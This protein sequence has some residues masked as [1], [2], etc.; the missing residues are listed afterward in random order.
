MGLEALGDLQR[1]YVHLGKKRGTRQR[2]MSLS[3]LGRYLRQ[4]RKCM[5][6][7]SS[8]TAETKEI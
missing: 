1:V 4:E 3:E 5:K 2:H 7:V 6:S 8:R